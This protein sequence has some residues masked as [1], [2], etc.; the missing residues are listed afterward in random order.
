MALPE[1]TPDKP[2]LTPTD[3]YEV[4][5]LLSD[6]ER[7]VRD[8]VRA[9]V[10]ECVLPEIGDHFERGSFPRELVPTMA[11]MGKA[12]RIQDCSAGVN[13]RLGR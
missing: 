2:S 9:L 13:P 6:D 5:D 11:A 7:M 8:S 3:L 12:L 1:R 4:D 10:R